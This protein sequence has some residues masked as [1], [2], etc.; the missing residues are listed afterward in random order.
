MTVGSG[1]REEDRLDD[2]SIANDA[3]IECITERLDNG[4]IVTDPSMDD[5]GSG[6][7]SGS[8]ATIESNLTIVGRYNDREYTR[9]EIEE[10]G[11]TTWV[12]L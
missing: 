10:S 7:G 12:C 4:S 8:A 2:I 11:Y 1:E 9:G 5:A 3:G 6:S